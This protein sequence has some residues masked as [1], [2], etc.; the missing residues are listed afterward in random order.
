MSNYPAGAEYDKNAPY[1]QSDP[2]PVEVD[3]T[4]S[5]SLSR[6]ATIEVTDYSLDQW[7]DYDIDDEGNTTHTGGVDYNFSECNFTEAY[8]SQEYT[9]PDL[10][11]ILS[12]LLDK[13]IKNTEN[14]SEK[15]RLNKILACCKEWIVDETEVVY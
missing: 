15:K 2:D 5:Q 3:V 9:I 10:L 1:N 6:Q 7:E 4:I 13:E 14:T 12:S 8:E 11:N